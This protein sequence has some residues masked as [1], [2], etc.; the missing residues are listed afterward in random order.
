[1]VWGLAD[2][3]PTTIAMMPG[4]RDEEGGWV[5]IGCR[6]GAVLVGRILDDRLMAR[7]VQHREGD[8]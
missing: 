3:Y 5:A 8:E 4:G 1:M 2:H 7:W 6:C